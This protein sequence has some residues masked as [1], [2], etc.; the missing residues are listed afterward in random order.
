MFFL[1]VLGLAEDV[2]GLGMTPIDR[3][4]AIVGTGAAVASSLLPVEAQAKKD[5]GGKIKNAGFIDIAEEAPLRGQPEEGVRPPWYDPAL[6]QVAHVASWP[7][8]ARWALS[9]TKLATVAPILYVLAGPNGL[10]LGNIR[11]LVHRRDGSIEIREK[12]GVRFLHL[13]CSSDIQSAMRL[14]DPVE[15]VLSYTRAMMGFLI[16]VQE[17]T[18]VAMIGLGGGSLL[19]FIRHYIPNSQIVVVEKN[20]R[21]IAAARSYFQV[22]DDNQ[23]FSVVEGQGEQW[24]TENPESCDVLMV[25]G[26]DGCCQVGGLATED[27]YAHARQALTRDGVMVV[28]LW[29]SDPQFHVNLQRIAHAFEYVVTIPA[30]CNPWCSGNMAVLAFAGRPRELRWSKLKP[31]ARELEARYGLEFAAMLDGIREITPSS[32]DEGLRRV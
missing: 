1:I 4:T 25:D 11:R 32:D 15:L 31:R 22:P 9:P 24:I 17:P 19:K 2:R 21:V 13:D 20:P 14:R 18:S 8:G 28:N 16:F 5:L 26:Y 29:P 30:A 27:F 3:R 7:N 12:K 6:L 23:L 10:M